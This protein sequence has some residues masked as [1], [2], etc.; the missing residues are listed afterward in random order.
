ML[1]ENGCCPRQ[2]LDFAC[3][4]LTVYCRGRG[5]RVLWLLWA[6]GFYRLAGLLYILWKLR[7]EAR[8]YSIYSLVSRESL[9]DV[10]PEA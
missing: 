8:I 7:I 1:Q 5:I 2:A 9:A 10:L 4:R 3:G 6:A